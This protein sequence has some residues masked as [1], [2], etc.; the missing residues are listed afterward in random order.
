MVAWVVLHQPAKVD[1]IEE[2]A[3]EPPA[4]VAAVDMEALN[5]Q[6]AESPPLE[7]ETPAAQ[8]DVK[9]P[10]SAVAAAPRPIDKTQRIALGA[11]MY[12]IAPGQKFAEIQ[13]HRSQ[14]SNAGTSFEW[15]TESASALEGV[16]Y[17]PQ[18]RATMAFSRGKQ[19]ASLFVKLL[20]NASRKRSDVFYVV[21]GNPS[22][23]SALGSV[24]KAKVALP[25][26]GGVNALVATR[27]GAS[28]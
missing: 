10:H 15:W 1:V 6:I 4:S 18:T 23:G 17:V 19:T 27:V 11:G 8:I 7:E 5:T 20:P 3:S 22:S 28:S 2:V 12:R 9:K 21:I 13:V 24:S 14:G 16:D 25:P 26:A